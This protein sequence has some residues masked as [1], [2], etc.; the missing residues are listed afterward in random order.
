MHADTSGLITTLYLLYLYLLYRAV[1]HRGGLSCMRQMRLFKR[2]LT[3]CFNSFIS[4]SYVR[5]A[6]IYAILD[7]LLFM[8]S[9][10]IFQFPSQLS[11]GFCLHGNYCVR[12]VN[13]SAMLIQFSLLSPILR[14]DSVHG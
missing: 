12:N 5:Y 3:V 11:T 4:L 10:L 6:K 7:S 13:A 14:I 8:K 2:T 9:I 1:R